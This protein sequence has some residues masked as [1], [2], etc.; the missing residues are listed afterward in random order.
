MKQRIEL[1][2]EDIKKEVPQIPDDELTPGQRKACHDLI[3]SSKKA[4]SILERIKK[5]KKDL[6]ATANENP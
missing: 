3:A 4:L 5:N 2:E 1:T 6:G